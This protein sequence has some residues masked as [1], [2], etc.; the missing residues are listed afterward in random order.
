MLREKYVVAS[1]FILY[2]FEKQVN[3][4][5]AEGFA[6]YGSISVTYI[7]SNNTIIYCQPMLRT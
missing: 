7:S 5:I 2:E 3:E 4:Y 1:H 6:P